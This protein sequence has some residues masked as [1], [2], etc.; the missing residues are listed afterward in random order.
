MEVAY[1]GT[2]RVVHTLL[3]EMASVDALDLLPSMANPGHGLPG[4]GNQGMGHPIPVAAYH[5]LPLHIQVGSSLAFS[6]Y[7]QYLIAM[8]P[9]RE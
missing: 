4:W 7:S 2:G 1:Y 5:T 8:G 3:I 9:N 6:P